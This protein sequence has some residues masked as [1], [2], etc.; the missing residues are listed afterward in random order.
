MKF[1]LKTFSV[2]SD[3]NSPKSRLILRLQSKLKINYAK[4]RQLA[5][6]K[7]KDSSIDQRHHFR[8]TEIQ[9]LSTVTSVQSEFLVR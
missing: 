1:Q 5:Q 3:G 6:Y 2:L 8:S 4:R 7:R 9:A